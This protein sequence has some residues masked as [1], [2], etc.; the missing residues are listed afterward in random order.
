M[1]V[2]NLQ[3]LSFLEVNESAIKS[4]GYSREEFLSMRVSEIRPPED[5]PQLIENLNQKRPSLE[6]SG[7]RRH[8]LKNG[9]FIDVE[10]ISHE[11]EFSGHRAA[12]VVALNVTEKRKAEQELK[13][14]EE[15]YRSLVSA[16]TSIVW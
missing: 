13:V 16:L 7:V 15:R 5:I 2:Y 3:T 10:I 6:S 11:T 4:Y 14:S 1:W 12:L 9:R 8:R